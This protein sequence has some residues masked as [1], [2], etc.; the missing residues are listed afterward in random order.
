MDYL[1]ECFGWHRPDVAHTVRKLEET[2]R[3]LSNRILAMNQDV[4]K[5]V[6]QAKQ[7]MEKGDR[8]TARRLLTRKQLKMQEIEQLDLQLNNVDSVMDAIVQSQDSAK[9]FDTVQ[10]ANQLLKRTTPKI[11]DLDR[12]I[13]DNI[14]LLDDTRSTTELLSRPLATEVD[15]VDEELDALMSNPPDWP[16]TEN[17]PLLQTKAPALIARLQTTPL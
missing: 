9:I 13:E 15:D 16:D 7:A 10:G 2:Q 17:L 11:A 4:H 6:M 12:T 1:L 3:L 5:L 8:A 14:E